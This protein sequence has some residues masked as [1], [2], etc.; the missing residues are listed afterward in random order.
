MAKKLRL[1]LIAFLLLLMVG[2][3]NEKATAPEYQVTETTKSAKIGTTLSAETTIKDFTEEKAI[4]VITDYT[5]KNSSKADLIRIRVFS[6][7]SGS[8]EGIL[9]NK[10]IM[11]I[12]TPIKPDNIKS[13]PTLWISGDGE[14]KQLEQ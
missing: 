7:K 6:D 14:F 1:F 11:A 9:I 13:T 8:T 5:D 12:T 3:G 4:S 10:K 2:C